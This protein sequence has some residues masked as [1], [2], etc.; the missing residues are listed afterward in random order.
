MIIIR[1]R[2]FSEYLSTRQRVKK[3]GSAGLR[4]LVYGA[5]PGGVI[6]SLGGK[7]GAIIGALATGIPIG[8]VS[9]AAS[10]QGSSKSSIDLENKIEAKTNA[11]ITKFEKGAIRDPKLVFAPLSDSEKKI[12]GYKNFEEK[13]SIKF[14]SEFYRFIDLQEEFIP[15]A[16]KW[17]KDNKGKGS[18]CWKDIIPF[19]Y[20][21]EDI[22]KY[23]S[24]GKIRKQE[25]LDIIYF[26]DSPEDCIVYYPETMKFKCWGRGNSITL[27][28]AILNFV[29]TVIKGIKYSDKQREGALLSLAKLYENFIRTRL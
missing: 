10:W 9:A 16:V 27:K 24:P 12:E 14:P 4:G 3:A 21:S 6:G 19:V 28:Q 25:P 5:I 11:A 18:Y 26:E 20:Y 29:D 8:A 23:Y 13:Y 17:V 15:I 22:E 2:L 1:Q 7:R